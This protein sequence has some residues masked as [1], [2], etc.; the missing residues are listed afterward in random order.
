M[1]SD[2]IETTV[3][4]EEKPEVRK[5]DDVYY[6]PAYIVENTVSALLTDKSPGEAMNLRVLDLACG[7]FFTG[8]YQYL[9]D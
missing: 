7:S 3:T 6:T 8:A 5:A 2:D 9:L 1:R 4:L